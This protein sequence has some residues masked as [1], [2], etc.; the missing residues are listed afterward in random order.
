MQSYKLKGKFMR[1]IILLMHASLDG[2]VGGPK[3]EMNWIKIDDELFDFVGKI[4]DQ[5]DVGLYGRVTYQMMESYWP[6]AG[7]KPNASKHDIEHSQWYKRVDK[8]VISNSMKGGK[9]PKVQIISGDINEGIG[10]LKQKEGKDILMLG[11]PSAS[12][13]LMHHNL[14]D[15]YWIFVNPIL[16]GVGIPLFKN[17]EAKVNLKFIAS[18]VFASGV[19]GLH[20]E[21]S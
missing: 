19:V 10:Q 13:A 16:L 15:E 8:V 17:I 3:G 6:T 12:H 21:K 2:F 18:K 9:I 20:Y 14:I 4:V 11:S 1:K 5:A 7:D